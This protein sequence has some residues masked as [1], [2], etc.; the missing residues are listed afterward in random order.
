MGDLQNVAICDQ[1]ANANANAKHVGH[2]KTPSEKENEND[3]DELN[4][5]RKFEISKDHAVYFHPSPAQRGFWQTILTAHLT[6]VPKC[7]AFRENSHTTAAPTS[8][9]PPGWHLKVNRILKESH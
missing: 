7:G 2:R 4:L 1:F 3:R 5:H 8:G 9:P 6:S